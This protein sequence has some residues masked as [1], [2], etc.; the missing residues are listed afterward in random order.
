MRI[1]TPETA[2]S[3]IYF[4]TNHFYEPWNGTDSYSETD[5]PIQWNIMDLAGR[6]DVTVSLW[7]YVESYTGYNAIIFDFKIV[8]ITILS[9]TDPNSLLLIISIMDRLMVL[10]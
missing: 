7:G 2:T 8:V 6:T 5:I 4:P 10:L 1:E 3:A 9:L